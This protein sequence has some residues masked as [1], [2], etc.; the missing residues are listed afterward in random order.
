MTVARELRS[1]ADVAT[2][3]AAGMCLRRVV[4]PD[5]DALVAQAIMACANDLAGM[6]PPGAIADIAILLGG[7]R[8]PM[9][10][11]IGAGEPLRAAVRAYDDPFVRQFLAKSSGGPITQEEW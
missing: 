3:L 7:A 11:T 5:D 9:S 10:T 1:A 2:W 6:P 4:T 8:L